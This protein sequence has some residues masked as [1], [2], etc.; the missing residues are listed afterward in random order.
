MYYYHSVA[1]KH[2]VQYVFSQTTYHYGN[3]EHTFTHGTSGSHSAVI[4]LAR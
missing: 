4:Q 2:L 3:K 1:A